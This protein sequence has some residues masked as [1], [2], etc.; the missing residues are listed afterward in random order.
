VRSALVILGTAL[1]VRLGV[2]WAVGAVRGPVDDEW[3]YVQAF[4]GATFWTAWA[5]KILECRAPGYPL[6]LRALHLL[7]VGR[8]GALALQALL[9]TAT[10]GLMM[11]LARRWMGAGV[12]STIGALLAVEPTLVAYS[13]LFMS[14]TLFVFLMASFFL[15][16]T[17]PGAGRRTTVAAGALLGL[18]LLTRST[19]LPFFG[20]LLI[21][22]LATDFWPR[23]ERLARATLLALAAVST[24]VP[25]TIRNALV[26]RELIPI[27]CYTMNSLW[28]GNNPDGWNVGLW[29]RY[30]EHSDSPTERERFAFQ[31]ARDFLRTQPPTYPVTK[32]GSV[33]W[34]LVAMEDRI[35]EASYGVMHR[36]GP[37]PPR[38]AAML[39]TIERAYFLALTALALVGF[40]LAARSPER[41]LVGVFAAAL[42]LG[43]WITFVYPR[44]RIPFVPF[45]ALFSAV[46]LCRPR[47]VWRPTRGRIVV[48][49]ALVAALALAVWR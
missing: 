12:G 3:A 35:A 43:H 40:T 48:A 17:W 1:V 20:A 29:K 42:L 22:M 34:R 27:D 14:E 49:T 36:Y 41:T 6:L 2:L 46:T 33:V 38:A 31:Q 18:T 8:G 16:L 11:L 4:Q 19:L 30:F 9:G 39:G 15:L 47:G 21:W 37:L 24:I 44:H 32:L 26:Y 5:P 28:L 13:V 25:W 45:L 23:P 7:G 10:V